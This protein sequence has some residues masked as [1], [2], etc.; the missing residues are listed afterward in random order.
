MGRDILTEKPAW[1]AYWVCVVMRVAWCL[2]VSKA[3]PVL[4]VVYTISQMLREYYYA[5]RRNSNS[6]WN[7]HCFLLKVHCSLRLD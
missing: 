4:R 6:N 7:L 1:D 3:T 5:G 2:L